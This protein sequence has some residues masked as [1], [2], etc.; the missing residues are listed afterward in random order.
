[1]NLANSFYY[2]MLATLGELTSVLQ[3]LFT[4]HQFN[5]LFLSFVY[6][7]CLSIVGLLLFCCDHGN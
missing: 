3:C 5:L 4:F 7:F 2:V 1:M 6:I